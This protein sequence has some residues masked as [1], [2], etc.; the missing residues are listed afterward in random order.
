MVI[1]N[2]YVELPEGKPNPTE[3]SAFSQTKLKVHIPILDK[4]ACLW[5]RIRFENSKQ[6]LHA[7]ARQEGIEGVGQGNGAGQTVVFVAHQWDRNK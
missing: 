3:S 5:Y 1:F 4:P 6:I 2:S 7:E